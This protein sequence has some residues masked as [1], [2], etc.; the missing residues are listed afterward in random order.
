MADLLSTGVSG[1]LAAQVGLAT[2]GHNVSNASTDGYS[3]QRVAFQANN[4]QREGSFY[5]GTG[6]TTVSVQRAYS[7]HLSSA[8]WS[9]SSSKSRAETY[10]ALTGQMNNDL[11]GPANVQTALDTFFG[12]VSDLA[13]APADP[14]ARQAMID[15]GSGLASTFRS[16]SGQFDQLGKQVQG[17]IQETVNAINTDSQA[18]AALNDRLRQSTGSEPSDLLDQR[19]TLV[20]K[21]STEVGVTVT[22]QADGTVNVYTGNG[23][24]LVNGIHSYA[25]GTAP[26][27][28]DATQLDVVDQ[29]SG[30]V[31]SRTLRGGSLGALLDF[32]SSVLAPAQNQL[33]RAALAVADAVNGQ[34]QQGVDLHG[35]LGTALFSVDGPAAHGAGTNTGSASLGVSVGDLG[36]LTIKDYTLSYDGSAWALRDT[37]GN[38]VALTG[39][40][41]SASP[42]VADGLKMTVSGSANAGDSFLIQ[43]T[44][45]ASGSL[46][47]AMTDPDRLAAA[48]ALKTSAG[49]SNSGT[50][51][52][53]D[54]SVVDGSNGS[55][56]TPASIAFTS[57]TSY[58]I[59]G[60]PAQ[61]FTA[62][63]PITANG[64]SLTLNGAPSSGDVFQVGPNTNATG[65]NSNA[66]KM[67]KAGGQPILDGGVTT[68][69][70]AYG[71]LVSKAGSVGQMA[72]DD[73]TTQK[74]VFDQA[75]GAQ[76]G[77]SGVNLDEEAANLT[78][79]QQAYQASAQVIATANSLFTSL[80]SAVNA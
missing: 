41:T 46:Q 20:Q 73:L 21:L 39:A 32:R 6:V 66:L 2:T 28:Y 49:T 19:D 65:D 79:F 7:Q 16:L 69:G 70:G 17:Q 50:A 22:Q 76:Q 3:R 63:S 60:G 36:A 62:G 72:N 45:T 53:Q 75:M 12:A 1:M 67:S 56:F 23:Q 35:Q 74:S 34:H 24:P 78:R 42:F 11:G 44:A 48:A 8:L 14:A 57:P 61:T 5:V 71:Q 10:Q 80:L 30:A 77:V 68:V 43:P 54:I 59:N 18:L 15:R 37:Q 33:G 13:N 47:M 52:V 55:L 29:Q 4:P 9:A 40:G 38:A 31:L 25:L 64:W 58:S 51:Q 27:T 26:G